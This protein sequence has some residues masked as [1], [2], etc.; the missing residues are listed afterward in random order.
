MAEETMILVLFGVLFVFLAM[1]LEIGLSV[2]LIAIIGLFVVINQPV[3]QAVTSSFELTNSFVLTA[4]PLFV[5]M[6]AIFTKSGITYYLFRGVDAW[7]G[8]LPGGMAVS[9]IGACAIFSAMSGSSLATAAAMGTLSLPEMERYHYEP[10]LALGTVAAGGTL[11][12]LI[13]PSINLILYGVWTSTSVIDLFAAGIIPGLMLAS[14]FVI[15][16]SGRV[17]LNPSL[18]PKT[19]GVTWRERL[20]FSAGIAPWVL[21]VVLVLGVIFT[22]VMTPTEAASLGAV[23]SIILALAYRRMN[24][25]ILREAAL[26]AVRICSMIFL[27]AAGAITLAY[28]VTWLGIPKLMIMTFTGLPVGKYGILVLI[29]IMYIILGM[30][31]DPISMM[32]LTLPFIAPVI[33]A[34]GYNLIWFGVV[35]IILSEMAFLTPPVGMNLYIIQ[36]IAPKYSVIT[37]ARGAMPFLVP[38]LLMLAIL[39]IWPEIALWLPNMLRMLR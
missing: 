24:L 5:L 26:M 28:V 14:L 25:R 21:T 7:V 17:M 39:I 27:V 35:L 30:F 6:G 2:M 9:V 10:K 34:I 18:A 8:R 37:V 13:P 36:S 16:V 23:I 19:P 12:I 33:I 15:L 20:K 38:M 11:G 3:V 29:G 31:F 22:G 32:L 4:I 1:G